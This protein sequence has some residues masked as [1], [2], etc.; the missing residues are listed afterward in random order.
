MACELE[1]Q[2]KSQKKR[3]CDKKRMKSSQHKESRL[4]SKLTR[5]MRMGRVDAKK[6][7][8]SSKV[9]MGVSMKSAVGAAAKTK[10]EKHPPMCSNCRVMGHKSNTCKMPQENKRRAHDL[11]DCSAED[12]MLADELCVSRC[13]QKGRRDA[14]CK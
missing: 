3:D 14:R 2:K 10:K 12:Y 8:K 13:K 5:D 4:I 7:H 6:T 1:Y 9:T 11:V